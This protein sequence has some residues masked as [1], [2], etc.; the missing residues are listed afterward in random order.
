MIDSRGMMAAIFAAMIFSILL[1]TLSGCAF[2]YPGKY[3]NVT[4]E[5]SPTPEM[6]EIAGLNRHTSRTTGDK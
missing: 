2:T 6:L 4:F 5:L 1:L 3:G